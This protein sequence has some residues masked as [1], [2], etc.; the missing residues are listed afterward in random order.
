[1]DI[2]KKKYESYF[3]LIAP[4]ENYVK[5]ISGSLKNIYEITNDAT[6]WIDE[7]KVA[8]SEIKLASINST[9]NIFKTMSTINR[10]TNI[11]HDIYK[12]LSFD[13]T[14]IDT[15][16]SDTYILQVAGEYEKIQ[17]MFNIIK[18]V[19][20][21][22]LFGI[23]LEKIK[24]ESVDKIHTLFKQYIDAVYIYTYYMQYKLGTAKQNSEEYECISAMI[25]ESINMVINRASI[26]KKK[27]AALSNFNLQR[28]GLVPVYQYMTP[29]EVIQKSLN[30]LFYVENKAITGGGSS[31][32]LISI[33]KKF[34]EKKIGLY[35]MMQVVKNQIEYNMNN[36]MSRKAVEKYNIPDNGG[37]NNDII[38]KFD[39]VRDIYKETDVDVQNLRLGDT[40]SDRWI[41]IRTLN[42]THFD[43][44]SASKS[45]L[46]VNTNLVDK[47]DR[48]PSL[49]INNYQRICILQLLPHIKD[50]RAVVIEDYKS[51]LREL[52]TNVQRAVLGYIDQKLRKTPSSLAELGEYIS[53]DE[54]R[55]IISMYLIQAYSEME[56]EYTTELSSTF[57]YATDVI[58]KKFVRKIR[59]K[60]AQSDMNE[61]MFREKTHNA[62][63]AHIHKNFKSIIEVASSKVFDPNKDIFDKIVTKK[64]LLKIEL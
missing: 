26:S 10:I 28:F 58:I 37:I 1:M 39:N 8:F 2:I 13:I 7:L 17:F 48:G 33:S 50:P 9:T 63:I 36:I 42:G 34:N 44:M 4:L 59:E 55:D 52:S 54:I 31:E 46:F 60:F 24:H 20:D 29:N 41:I 49:R 35:V 30:V 32:G 56:T 12:R 62:L 21:S 57:L 23:L 27:I 61:F 11:F 45:M 25:E 38:E 5:K 15:H 47:I 40:K 16:M 19:D 14:D 18:N 64:S 22:K 53:G 6:A 43:I 3:A 51:P